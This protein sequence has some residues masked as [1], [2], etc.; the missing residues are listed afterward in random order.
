MH[1]LGIGLYG[2]GW[3]EDLISTEEDANEPSDKEST[4]ASPQSDSTKDKVLYVHEI[5]VLI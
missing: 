5:K 4:P 2:E 3:T 1:T